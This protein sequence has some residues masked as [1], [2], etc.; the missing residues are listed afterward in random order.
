MDDSARTCE[1]NNLTDTTRIADSQSRIS[2]VDFE[3]VIQQVRR[4]SQVYFEGDKT[5]SSWEDA[6]RAMRASTQ[7]IEAVLRMAEEGHRPMVYHETPEQLYV[8]T[9]LTMPP[10]SSLGSAYNA[11]AGAEVNKKNEELPDVRKV[12][13]Q[14]TAVDRV[15]AMGAKLMP[16]DHWERVNL[17]RFYDPNDRGEEAH[18]HAKWSFLDST[19]YLPK[20]GVGMPSVVMAA[21]REPTGITRLLIQTPLLAGSQVGFHC[22]TSF[23][24]LA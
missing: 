14:G 2:A 5:Q 1:P 15:A 9:G 3:A 12:R 21:L 23:A 13:W 17:L 4:N 11:A 16:C 19:R 10:D 18:N 6:E 22:F 7:G 24:K 20:S 8:G